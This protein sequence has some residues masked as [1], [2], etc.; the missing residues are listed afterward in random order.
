MQNLLLQAHAGFD[1]IAVFLI[2][3]ILTFIIALFG[4]LKPLFQRFTGQKQH[5]EQQK[6]LIEQNR[7]LMEELKQARKND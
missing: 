3:V 1:W 6:E 2:V 7:Q 5:L 4:A